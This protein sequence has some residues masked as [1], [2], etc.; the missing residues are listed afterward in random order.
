MMMQHGHTQQR[1]FFQPGMK[2]GAQNLGAGLRNGKN[3][4]EAIQQM[5]DEASI[6][7][8]DGH[9]GSTFTQGRRR[10]TDIFS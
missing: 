4:H 2:G 10:P 8:I 6:V 9:Q 3:R 5:H 7:R 1:P